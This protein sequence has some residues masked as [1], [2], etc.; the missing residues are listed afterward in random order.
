MQHTAKTPLLAGEHC[1]RL[2]LSKVED[3]DHLYSMPGYGF[4]SVQLEHVLGATTCIVF[5]L[6]V[7][8]STVTTMHD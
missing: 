2:S 7:T 8:D 4:I 3:N 1:V 5:L 6:R